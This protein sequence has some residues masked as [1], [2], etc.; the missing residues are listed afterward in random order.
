MCLWVANQLITSVDNAAV[1]VDGLDDVGRFTRSQ[2]ADVWKK[3]LR[4]HVG[5]GLIDVD[6]TEVDHVNHGSIQLSAKF[7]L[8]NEMLTWVE[9]QRDDILSERR[10]LLHWILHVLGE[11]NTV[12]G[13]RG[14][15]RMLCKSARII[16]I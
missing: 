10:V 14:N 1:H 8:W 16:A 11:R 12:T 2:S 5:D 13:V 6:T 3:V 7:L 4:V 9:D 15:T